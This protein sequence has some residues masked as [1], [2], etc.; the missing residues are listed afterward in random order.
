M[1][2]VLRTVK[3]QLFT[4]CLSI[5]LAR[6]VGDLDTKTE[7]FKEPKCSTT[8]ESTQ[9]RVVDPSCRLPALSSRCGFPCVTKCDVDIRRDLYAK[10]VLSNGIA[11]F[12]GI[13][14]QM[15]KVCN[16]SYAKDLFLSVTVSVE[17]SVGTK[18]AQLRVSVGMHVDLTLLHSPLS[19]SCC[20]ILIILPAHSR[21]LKVATKQSCI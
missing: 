8:I 11:M 16:V 17:V 15:A 2:T 3:V 19:Q 7:I 6:E 4:E 9:S 13:G 14:E 1:V 5:L 20:V 21:W 18:L 10:V 12:Q